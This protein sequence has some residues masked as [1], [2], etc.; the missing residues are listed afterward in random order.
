MLGEGGMAAVQFQ[1]STHGHLGI[2]GLSAPFIVLHRQALFAA[3]GTAKKV[4]VAGAKLRAP[5]GVGAPVTSGRSS[6]A[7]NP[8]ALPFSRTGTSGSSTTFPISCRHNSAP[9]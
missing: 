2:H 3:V 6:K 9:Q 8:S 7:L 1:E 4:I 5:A